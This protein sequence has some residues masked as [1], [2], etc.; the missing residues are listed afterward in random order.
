[1]TTLLRS[2]AMTP[3]AS[4]SPTAADR[5]SGVSW[6][7]RSVTG[8]PGMTH[9]LSVVVG[10]GSSCVR[11]ADRTRGEHHYR[12]SGRAKDWT[13]VPESPARAPADSTAAPVAILRSIVPR[14]V[15]T[16]LTE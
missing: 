4:S 1:M 15:C 9:V 14:I 7:D 11:L 2:G 12:P 3:Q 16:L 8:L 10:E 13:N 6:A 5:C